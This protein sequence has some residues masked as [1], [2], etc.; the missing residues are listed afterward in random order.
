MKTKQNKRN[1]RS[2]R[3]KIQ[4]RAASVRTNQELKVANQM[5]KDTGLSVKS[6]NDDA[7]FDNYFQD[8]GDKVSNEWKSLDAVM[9]P[10]NMDLSMV[11]TPL[12]DT[13]F[14]CFGQNKKMR[15]MITEDDAILGSLNSKYNKSADYIIQLFDVK[16]NASTI[17]LLNYRK[18]G[19]INW[20][21]EA[22][23]LSKAE[24]ALTSWLLDTSEGK[25]GHPFYVVDDI[26][27]TVADK[28]LFGNVFSVLN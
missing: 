27:K 9:T 22:L 2:N 20:R 11:G 19:N 14:K 17:L 18:D 25:T 10:Y 28:N 23:P 8:L 3:K 1:I 24:L 5:F 4:K 6:F 15:C 16:S 13:T 21:G 12:L 26:V 7:D